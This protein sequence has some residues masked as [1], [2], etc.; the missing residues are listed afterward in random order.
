MMKSTFRNCALHLKWSSHIMNL[1]SLFSLYQHRLVSR[2]SQSKRHPQ[3]HPCNA[4]YT[5]NKPNNRGYDDDLLTGQLMEPPSGEMMHNSRIIFTSKQKDGSIIRRMFVSFTIN[6]SE[7]KVSNSAIRN[8]CSLT[9]TPHY[10][11]TYTVF[12]S[13]NRIYHW[14]N[15]SRL[16]RTAS[17]TN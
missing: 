1:S 17:S 9:F 6:I 10:E 14:H 5:D 3:A 11:V 16:E 2:H 12:E 4:R 8:V 7:Q 15:S 13:E